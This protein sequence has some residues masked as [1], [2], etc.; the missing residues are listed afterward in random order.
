MLYDNISEWGSS[1]IGKRF[2][3]VWGLVYVLDVEDIEHPQALQIIFDGGL[4]KTISCASDGAK[5]LLRDVPMVESDLG[6]YGKQIIKDISINSIF[7]DAID[8]ELCRLS[9]IY[10]ET[11]QGIIGL[12]FYFSNFV[13]INVI[14][15]GDEINI[16]GE[17]PKN[18]LNE[19]RISFTE[20]VVK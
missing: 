8:K 14:N 5:L 19:E 13:T 6:E 1:I 16:Y 10:S 7:G 9:I 2:K 12:N 18:I 4:L 17:I 20:V 3:S 11:E 15:L